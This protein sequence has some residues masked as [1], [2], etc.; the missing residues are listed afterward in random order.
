M[1]GIKF[2]SD[3]YEYQRCLR[4]AGGRFD[5]PFGVDEFMPAGLACGAT[6]A[7]GSTYNYAAPLYL[8]MMESFKR[9]DHADVAAC[10]DKVI[11]IIRVL[12]E[13]GGVAAG[14]VAMQLHDID[15]GDPRRPLRPMTQAQKQDALDKF[16]KANFI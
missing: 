2:N 9:G 14:K 4:V 3:M 1:S 7:V 6:S 13:Y 8:Q 12:V 11:G 16:R 10:M 15:A 5:I